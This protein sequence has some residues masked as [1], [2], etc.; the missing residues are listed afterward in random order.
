VEAMA[1]VFLCGSGQFRAKLLDFYLCCNCGTVQNKYREDHSVLIAFAAFVY[2]QIALSVYVELGGE[3]ARAG[4][5]IAGLMIE[6][7]IN[8]C[9]DRSY[10]EDYVLAGEFIY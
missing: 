2:P 9:T 8:G 5:A 3:G 1:E 6:K 4:A 7:Y 10:M